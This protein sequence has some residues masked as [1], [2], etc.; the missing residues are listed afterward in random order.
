LHFPLSVSDEAD[1]DFAERPLIG[2]NAVGAADLNRADERARQQYFAGLQCLIVLSEP[3]RKPDDALGGMA[4]HASGEARFLDL[5]VLA[6]IAPM[7]RKSTPLGSNQ[8]PPSTMPALVA[9]S[10]IVSNTV[11]VRFVCGSTWKIRASRI[12]SGGSHSLLRRSGI[13]L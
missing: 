7:W 4:K 1:G 10:D 8:R 13:R 5:A 9:L 11:R 2:D 6:T 3:G 12:S